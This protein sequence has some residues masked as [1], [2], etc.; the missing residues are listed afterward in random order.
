[1]NILIN[2]LKTSVQIT[3]LVM[4]MMLLIEYI[5]VR[6][7]GK[8]F[9][10]LQNSKIKQV[11]FSTLLGLVPG[12]VGGFAV[13]SLFTHR[14]VS[15]GALIA[16]MI[17]SSGDEAFIM[18][19]MI[20]KEALI[21]FAILTV[22]AVS[23]GIIVDKLF[24]VPAPFTKEHFEIHTI[25]DHSHPVIFSNSLL[26]NFKKISKERV[27]IM[28]GIAIFIIASITGLAGHEHHGHEEDAH[29]TFN[30]F[31][32]K[33]ISLI[34]TFISVATLY[35]TAIANEHFI[36]DHLWN[37]VVKKHFKTIFFWTL[38]ALIVIYFGIK[39]MNIES[40][41]QDNVFI[42]ILIAVLIGIIPESGPHIVFITMFAEGTVP[43][44]VLLAS[45]IVQD[46]HTALPLLAESK[47]CFIKAKIIN[48]IIGFSLG[49]IFHLAGF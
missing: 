17:A 12:C 3:G 41:I 22:V 15:F 32:E 13:V 33:W 10:G 24:N 31:D 37:H 23:A 5:N 16:M 30:I 20:P 38:G 27:L 48:M 9:A 46:G 43:F 19:A 45:S 18:L 4:V 2:A 1:M 40:W 8:T 36:K 26:S 7:R 28:A 35:L 6:S 44:S 39:Y 14:I 49:V 25:E 42:M 11:I 47:K 21:L 29:G 34:F